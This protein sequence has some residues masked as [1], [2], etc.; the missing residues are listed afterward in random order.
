LS[1]YL[2]LYY[3]NIS[4]RNLEILTTIS[5]IVG[6]YKFLQTEFYLRRQ[7]EVDNNP[8]YFEDPNILIKYF[9]NVIMTEHE[10]IKLQSLNILKNGVISKHN[11][12]NK[13]KKNY[14]SVLF[15]PRQIQYKPPHV[16]HMSSSSL[17][18]FKIEENEINSESIEIY[19]KL[20]Y[21]SINKY[22]LFS[23]GKRILTGSNK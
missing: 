5:K 7:Y 11:K 13:Y 9:Y 4:Q 14:T 10:K 2:N 17:N 1:E 20:K 18:F 12:C 23:K 15:L 8:L 6:N 21:H 16:A 3:P 19:S 22:N